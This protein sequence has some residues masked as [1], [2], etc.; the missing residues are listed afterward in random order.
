MQSQLECLGTDS[1]AILSILNLNDNEKQA[2]KCQPDY[3]PLYKI[4]PVLQ[5]LTEQCQEVYMPQ[6]SLTTDETVCAF[7]G[8]YSFVCMKWKPHRYGIK[9]LELCEAKSRY[10]SNLEVY[11]GTD[12]TNNEHNTASNVV[13]RLSE[14][15]KQGP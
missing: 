2:Q 13:D 15:E 8:A 14:S 10:V 7:R 3:D 1:L 4:Q 9:I 6:E 12:H 5:I 11:I